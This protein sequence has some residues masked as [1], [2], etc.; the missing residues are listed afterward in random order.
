MTNPLVITRLARAKTAGQ[1]AACRALVQ[2]WYNRYVSADPSPTPGSKPGAGRF[3]TFLRAERRRLG[4]TQRAVADAIQVSQQ[5]VANWETGISSPTASNM[6]GLARV[7]GRSVDELNRA[8]DNVFDL[9]SATFEVGRPKKEVAYELLELAKRGYDE[10]VVRR[11]AQEL[12][13]GR[14]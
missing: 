6:S 10:E 8:A 7:L 11:I 1:D 12:E 2:N 14:P 4:L 13:I 9:P 5:T 3:P